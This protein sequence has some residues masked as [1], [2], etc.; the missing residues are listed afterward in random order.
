[1]SKKR[2]YERKIATKMA[3]HVSLF[4][5]EESTVSTLLQPWASIFQNGFLGGVQFKLDK[6]LT[7]FPDF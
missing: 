5:L 3:E 2:V 4:L 7:I 6:N 1:M